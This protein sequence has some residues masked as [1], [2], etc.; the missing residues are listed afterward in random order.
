MACF[1]HWLSEE[2]QVSSSETQ[3]RVVSAMA[4]QIMMA[5]ISTGNSIE[6]FVF[7]ALC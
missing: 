4:N 1:L 7:W 3:R 5:M 2:G 6:L